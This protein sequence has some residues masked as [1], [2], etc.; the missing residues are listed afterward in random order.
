MSIGRGNE[1]TE[2]SGAEEFLMFVLTEMFT[3]I[4]Q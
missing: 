2:D 3:G 4:L 1:T